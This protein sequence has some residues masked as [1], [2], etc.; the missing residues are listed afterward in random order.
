MFAVVRK[1]FWRR[2][3]VDAELESGGNDG[4]NGDSD[5]GYGKNKGERREF[6]D[7]TRQVESSRARGV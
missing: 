4:S 1:G 3:T 2:A 7:E 5:K 6:Q